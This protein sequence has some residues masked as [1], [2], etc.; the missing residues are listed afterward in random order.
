[1][2]TTITAQCIDQTL[3]LTNAPKLAS[4][5]ENEFYLEL[6][7]DSKWDGYGKEAVVYKDKA[8]I[9]RVV[10][11]DDACVLPWEVTAEPGNVHL[12]IRGVSGKTVR[13]SEEIILSFVQGP[14]AAGSY[15]APLPDVYKQVLSAQGDN[16]RAIKAERARIDNLVSA[17]T[18]DAEL[19]DVRVGADGITYGSAGSAVRGQTSQL[20]KTV[21]TDLTFEQGSIASADGTNTDNVTNRI[22]TGFILAENFVQVS[23]HLN[24][25]VT[26]F[27]YDASLQYISTTGWEAEPIGRN[28]LDPAAHYL[29]FVVAR[30]DAT[31]LAVSD[32]TGFIFYSTNDHVASEL[33]AFRN[34]LSAN[35]SFESGTL[36]AHDGAES[37]SDTRIR[38][39]YL[40]KAFE[41][42][43]IDTGFYLNLF[44]YDSSYKFLESTDFVTEVDPSVIRLDCELIR[45]VIRRIGQATLSPTEETGFT[46]YRNDIS[47]GDIGKKAD[48]AKLSY[49]RGKFNGEVMNI[50]Y[51]DIGIAPINTAEHFQ[52]A[53][54]LGFNALKGDVRITFDNGLIMCHDAGFTTDKVTNRIE[55]YDSSRAS[56]FVNIGY[57]T[58]MGF[59]YEAGYDRLGH[60]AKMC[61]FDTFI[62]ICKEN[63]KIA[64]ITLR[65]NKIPQLVSGVM[66][67]LRKYHMEDHCV[68]N[69][70]TL[71]T[72][73]EVR[74]YSDTIPLSQV[75]SL[76]DTLTRTVVD[77]VHGLGNSM[78]TMFLYPTD[79]PLELW[80]QS[81]DALAYAQEKGVQIH[82]A[83]VSSYSDYSDMV[84]RGVQGFHLTKPILDY[85]REDIQ[86]TVKMT[87]GNA[88]FGNIL[89]S[90]RLTAD[91]TVSDGVVTIKNIARNG[92]GYGYDDGLPA[93]WL[94]C[95]PG[96]ASATCSTNEDCS[97]QIKNGALVLTTN[98]IDGTY[99]VNVNI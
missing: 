96:T 92:S 6:E 99:Y 55:A 43:K 48:D 57:A 67:V 44:Q 83:Q 73:Q 5:G 25:I 7:F 13:T 17:E 66:D 72:L 64:Y 62:R 2:R 52:L 23:V 54:H 49:H 58:L 28:V 14:P 59:E 50:A 20:F 93:L 71:A 51:S 75:I 88:V 37:A 33:S 45:F 24:F 46:L 81:A 89:G 19:V 84:Q 95:L 21:A 86:F 76:G 8:R 27:Q 31:D 9:Y 15:P 80:E 18:V 10:M 60:Y 22:R 38:T 85:K 97:V 79:N 4:G 98:N 91:L 29:R 16:A 70:Y 12:A 63:G 90:D 30:A 3:T 41:R 39:G 32:N 68:I 26:M 11:A 47:L 1:M 61:N 74:K 78:V 65:E 34:I 53:A 69:S 77:R 82:M 40:D 35:V 42:V 87:S 56:M 36:N 94:N